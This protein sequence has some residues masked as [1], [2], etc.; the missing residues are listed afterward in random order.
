MGAVQD[1][2]KGGVAVTSDKTGVDRM[3]LMEGKILY[4]ITPSS[5]MEL[6]CFA[7]ESRVLCKVLSTIT[8]SEV[9]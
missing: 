9:R 4:F 7:F 6:R 8:F 2:W 5:Q 1:D 3:I